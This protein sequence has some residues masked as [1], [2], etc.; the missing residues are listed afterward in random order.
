MRDYIF[1]L[2]T[3]FLFSPFEHLKQSLLNRFLLSRERRRRRRT[4]T[5]TAL[6]IERNQNR[7]KITSYELDRLRWMKPREIDPLSI[8]TSDRVLEQGIKSWRSER[9]AH[10][11]FSNECVLCFVSSVMSVFFFH[12]STFLMWLIK[13]YFRAYTKIRLLS[14]SV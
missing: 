10:V 5:R 4:R 13:T 14:L 3:V 11:L 7:K 8:D 6:S 12:L 1:A 9:S 2:L